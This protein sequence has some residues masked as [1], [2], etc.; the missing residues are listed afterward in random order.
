MQSSVLV[1]RGQLGF[2]M[3]NSF[4]SV[5]LYVCRGTPKISLVTEEQHNLIDNTLGGPF[6]NKENAM[7]HLAKALV[8]IVESAERMS[9]SSIDASAP[10]SVK[11]PSLLTVRSHP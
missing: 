11:H 4:E 10:M 8:H 9:I 2:S 6:I 3:L 5:V 1:D 7:L